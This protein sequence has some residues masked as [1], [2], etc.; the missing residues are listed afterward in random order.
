MPGESPHVHVHRHDDY[1]LDAP[2]AFQL[3]SQFLSDPSPMAAADMRAYLPDI[4][5][6]AFYYRFLLDTAELPE[7]QLALVRQFIAQA[8]AAQQVL[9]RYPQE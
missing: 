6:I 2:G 1:P 8:Y 5:N 9:H 7:S 4:R 3:L